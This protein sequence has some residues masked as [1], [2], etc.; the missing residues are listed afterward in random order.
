MIKIP[1]GKARTG[2]VRLATTRVFARYQHRHRIKQSPVHCGPMLLAQIQHAQG[3]YATALLVCLAMQIVAAIVSC[4]KI[5]SPPP[6]MD[7][8]FLWREPAVCTCCSWSPNRLRRRMDQRST[9]HPAETR[10]NPRLR[11]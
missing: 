10:N 3:T 8:F 11:A 4:A 7:W 9:R 6:I 1:A 5:E 2:R